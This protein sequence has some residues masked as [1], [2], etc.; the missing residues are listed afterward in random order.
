MHDFFRLDMYRNACYYRN[1]SNQKKKATQ[2]DTIYL[3]IG[4]A[5]GA[6]VGVG[7]GLALFDNPGLGI[8]IG[9][10]LG[11]AVGAGLDAYARN[12]KIKKK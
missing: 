11:V 3:P 9:M 4:L 10:A 5:L 2:D 6:G 8:G 1:M 12:K 7:L